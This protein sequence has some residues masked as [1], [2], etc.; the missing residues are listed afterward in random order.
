LQELSDAF[1]GV[2]GV[3]ARDIKTGAEASIN[4]DRL[5]PMASV[6]KVLRLSK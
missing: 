1:P 3:T 2:I 4:G 6:Y 5:F